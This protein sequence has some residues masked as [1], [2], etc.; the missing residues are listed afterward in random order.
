LDTGDG[1]G[2]TVN[3]VF[4]QSP[5]IFLQG[6]SDLRVNSG[7]EVSARELTLGRFFQLSTQKQF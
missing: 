7:A 2:F 3:N 4:D 6:G 1:N 5:P